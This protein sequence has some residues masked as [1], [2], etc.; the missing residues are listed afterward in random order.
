MKF[1]EA[2]SPKGA[3]VKHSILR[4]PDLPKAQQVLE[5]VTW[6]VTSTPP[7]N[8]K[9]SNVPPAPTVFVTLVV[10]QENLP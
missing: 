5:L 2:L 6:F 10:H 9:S 4:H 3:N 7:I 1:L 8:T